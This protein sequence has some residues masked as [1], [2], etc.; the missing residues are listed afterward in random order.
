MALVSRLLQQRQLAAVRK[1]AQ[2]QKPSS[3]RPGRLK[4]TR[5]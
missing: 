5:G 2:R 4:R 3:T 1:A